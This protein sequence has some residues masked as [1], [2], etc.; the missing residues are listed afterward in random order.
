MKDSESCVIDGGH[1]TKYYSLQRRA[2]QG[3]PISAYLFIIALDILFALIFA[4]KDVPGLN[5]FDHEFL[6]T[7]YADDTTF[8]VKDLNSAKEVLIDLTL[9]SNVSGLY[10]NLEKCQIPGIGHLKNVNV[11][12]CGIKSVNLMEYFIK[13]LSDHI[14]YNKKLPHEF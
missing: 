6:Y 2:W 9:Y 7:A 11:A 1:T 3:N 13:I 12:L 14:S 8:F 10:P 4:K 5:I